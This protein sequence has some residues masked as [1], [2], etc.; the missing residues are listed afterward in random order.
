MREP[1]R[2]RRCGAEAMSGDPLG[3]QCPRCLL[4]LAQVA[5][6]RAVTGRPGTSGRRFGDFTL[7]GRVGAGPLG[8][9]YEAFEESTGR[10]V[11]VKV[12]DAALPR[13]DEGPGGRKPWVAA[14]LRH[15]GIVAV[16]AHGRRD[17]TLYVATELL[18]QGSFRRSIDLAHG[19]DPAGARRLVGLLADAC[20][21]L[22]HAHGEGVVHAGIKPENL[23]FD[24]DGR[25]L[26]L[27]DFEPANGSAV[28]CVCWDERPSPGARYLAPEQACEADSASARSDVYSLAACL[29]EAL[30]P[31][32]PVVPK[33]SACPS[34]PAA[35][36]ALLLRCLEVDPGRRPATAG[37][38]K[39]ALR[40]T[41]DRWG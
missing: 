19:R 32:G 21:A 3:H 40:E 31:E 13:E 34:M 18:R 8:A 6:G 29:W 36:E 16:H 23:L 39:G 22:E 26:L 28:H 24:D 15:P 35:L 37:E 10:H 17:D 4:D 30:A 2:C 1:S 41:I 20:A 7:M 12:W 33:R 38:L 27:A 14:T 5:K 11:A 9:V 25:R